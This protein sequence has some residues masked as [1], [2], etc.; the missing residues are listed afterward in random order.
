MKLFIILR[1]FYRLLLKGFQVDQIVAYIYKKATTRAFPASGS[2]SACG[3]RPR[4]RG[5]GRL[6]AL[7][8]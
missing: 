6:E 5:T 4:G 2:P 8:F 1:R 7:R 3:A